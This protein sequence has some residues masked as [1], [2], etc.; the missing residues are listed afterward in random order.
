MRKI[1]NEKIAKSA[2][3]EII[4]NTDS[5]P[6]SKV[7]G[8]Y[9]SI[10]SYRISDNTREIWLTDSQA[11]DIA[12]AIIMSLEESDADNV[13]YDLKKWQEEDRY[14]DSES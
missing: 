2:G 9:H 1:R 4:R 14:G 3:F 11:V 12:K 5:W 7:D 6:D 13:M 8:L 10:V